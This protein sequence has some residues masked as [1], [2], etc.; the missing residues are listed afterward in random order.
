MLKIEITDTENKI[1]SP[2][3]TLRSRSKGK[4]LT[5]HEKKEIYKK[6]ERRMPASDIK[7]LYQVSD[8]TI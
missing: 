1:P 8:S 6:F 7:E 2:E 4:W 3:K 5:F